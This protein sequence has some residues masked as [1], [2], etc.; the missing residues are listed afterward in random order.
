MTRQ[1]MGVQ[2]IP[3]LNSA[4]LEDFGSTFQRQFRIKM[5]GMVET[6]VEFRVTFKAADQ[7]QGTLAG[8]WTRCRCSWKKKIEVRSSLPWIQ[9]TVGN[10][11]LGDN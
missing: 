5:V 2:S 9:S 6:V 4:S 10:W 3:V 11:D 8:G 1:T 7:G